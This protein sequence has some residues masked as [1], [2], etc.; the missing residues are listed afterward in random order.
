MSDTHKIPSSELSGKQPLSGSYTV[1]FQMNVKADDNVFIADVVQ[2]LAAGFSGEELLK[3]IADIKL[4]KLDKK[5][6]AYS[7]LK[8]GDTV[9][10]S[11]TIKVTAKIVHDNGFYVVGPVG[12]FVGESEIVL[13]RGIRAYVNKVSDA[14]VELVDFDQAVPVNL[15]DVETNEPT[16]TDVNIDLLILNTDS[17]ERVEE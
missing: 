17:V 1:S 13:P 2:A 10:V 9:I 12:E 7:V 14:G 6:N 15:L 8:A 16:E 4:E 11:K 3:K 5:G